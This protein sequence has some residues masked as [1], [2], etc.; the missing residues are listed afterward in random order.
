MPHGELIELPSEVMPLRNGTVHQ[1]D[2]PLVVSRLQQV[3]QLVHHD[4]FDAF[5]GLLGQLRVQADIARQRAAA[6]PPRSHPL[7]E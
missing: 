2:E 5:A 1:G 6:P 7:D 4:V 3:K